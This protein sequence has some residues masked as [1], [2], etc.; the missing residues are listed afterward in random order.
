[1]LDHWHSSSLR[2][3]EWH[4]GLLVNRG[5]RDDGTFNLGIL[6]FDWFIVDT[7]SHFVN[8]INIL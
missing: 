8:K 1:M 5:N 6:L 4:V 3:N 2:L 7:V